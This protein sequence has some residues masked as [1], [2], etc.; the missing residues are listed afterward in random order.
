MSGFPISFPHPQPKHSEREMELLQKLVA[1]RLRRTKLDGTI[2][3]LIFDGEN[4]DS[5]QKQQWAL[6]AYESV[7]KP[8]LVRMSFSVVCLS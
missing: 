4:T 5:G 2:Q 8:S 7:E 6:F 1:L 3:P